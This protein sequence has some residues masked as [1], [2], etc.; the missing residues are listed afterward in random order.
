M[1]LQTLRN[2]ERERK[3][4]RKIFKNASILTPIKS[5]END[6]IFHG[7]DGAYSKMIRFSNLNYLVL[8][9]QEK[10]EFIMEWYEIINTFSAGATYKISIIKNKRDDESFETET[11]LKQ[12]KDELAFYRSCYNE[13]LKQRSGDR[14]NIFKSV[15]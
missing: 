12:K 3:E 4:K 13:M 7:C 2:I 8:T 15:D 9:D 5:V 1:R 14:T 6:G 11:L 10:K